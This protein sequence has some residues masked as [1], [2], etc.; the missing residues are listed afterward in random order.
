MQMMMRRNNDYLRGLLQLVEIHKRDQSRFDESLLLGL[1]RNSLHFQNT[2]I[3]KQLWIRQSLS[4]FLQNRKRS[5][6]SFKTPSEKSRTQDFHEVVPKNDPQT[7]DATNL[8]M[9]KWSTL[10][11]KWGMTESVLCSKALR[12]T[13]QKILSQ[14]SPYIIHDESLL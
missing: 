7:E 10:I 11:V 8:L 13:T 9:M 14:V 5:S 4:I 2:K 6:K 1:K 3:L 12:K